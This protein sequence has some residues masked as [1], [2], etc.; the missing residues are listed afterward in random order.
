MVSC[1]GFHRSS[2]LVLPLLSDTG[3]SVYLLTSNTESCGEDDAA[4]PVVDVPMILTELP[5]ERTA[6]VSSRKHNFD[7]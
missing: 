4:G 3:F 1:S 2:S 6:G 5:R 7:E